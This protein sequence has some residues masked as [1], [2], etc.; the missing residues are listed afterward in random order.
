MKKLLV[1]ALLAASCLTSCSKDEPTSVTP[2]NYNK[3]ATGTEFTYMKQYTDSNSVIIAGSIDTLVSTVV[4]SN[5]TILGKPNAFLIEDLSQG[6]RDTGTYAYDSN[7]N[8]SILLEL[9]DLGVAPFWVTMP[10]ATQG[11]LVAATADSTE[12]GPGEFAVLKVTVTSTAKGSESVTVGSQAVSSKKIGMTVHIERI[13]AGV[14]GFELSMT[15][16]FYY[17]P[18][19]GTLVKLVSPPMK[20]I[21]SGNWME[22]SIQTL[23]SVKP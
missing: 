22:G 6:Y 1:F 4:Q 16:D 11:T 2:E 10:V 7:N 19:L 23:I 14:K 3:V 8:V 5:I 15:N 9:G 17:A 13:V 18:S 21:I 20:D 12:I